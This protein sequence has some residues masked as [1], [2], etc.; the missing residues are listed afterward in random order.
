[1]ILLG[2]KGKKFVENNLAEMVA[3]VGGAMCYKEQH[4]NLEG[5]RE[6]YI[7]NRE[8]AGF[9]YKKQKYG[10]KIILKELREK[11]VKCTRGKAKRFYRYN[12]KGHTRIVSEL[13]DYW[14]YIMDYI[15]NDELLM[16]LTINVILKE[17]KCKLNTEYGNCL[18]NILDWQYKR[19]VRFKTNITITDEKKKQKARKLLEKLHNYSGFKKFQIQCKSAHNVL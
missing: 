16:D 12:T 5:Y 6:F 18:N 2:K 9:H 4:K 10:D 14:K 7:E 11:G 3:L 13:Y 19:L 8:K 15:L 17:C 1:M